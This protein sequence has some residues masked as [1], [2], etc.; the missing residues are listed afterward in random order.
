MMD[1]EE[2][3]EEGGKACLVK[4]TVHLLGRW[5][6]GTEL[7]VCIWHQWPVLGTRATAEQTLLLIMMERSK[8]VSP[9]RCVRC[10]R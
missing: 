2:N 3:K 7:L 4:W 10:I 1:S 6:Q 8:Q 5:C 9:K